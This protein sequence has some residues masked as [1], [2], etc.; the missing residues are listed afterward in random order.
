MQRWHGRIGDATA[1]DGAVLRYRVH[2]R[3]TPLDELDAAAVHARLGAPAW[4][5]ERV[6]SI[7]VYGLWPGDGQ[8]W[9]PDPRARVYALDAPP[10]T[11]DGSPPHCAL[12]VETTLARDALAQRLHQAFARDRL[13][14]IEVDDELP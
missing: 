8:L 14:K 11:F 9:A 12:G 13:V 5:L 4:A 2:L 10:V 3:G 7:V 1:G 6:T